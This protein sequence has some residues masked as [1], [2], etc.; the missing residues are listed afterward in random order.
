MSQHGGVNSFQIVLNNLD[1]PAKLVYGF[2]IVI[3]IVYSSAIPSEYR[4]FAD[5]LLG[6]VFGIGII[7]SVT[8]FMGWVYGLLTA[9]AFLL[10]LN[11]ASRSEG[12]NGT[13][14]SQKRVGNQW[15]VEKLLD[16]KTKKIETNK[17]TTQAIHS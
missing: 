7:Y 2:I 8:H 11:G 14:T 10:I 9:M 3:I 15:F 16:E 5:S 17:V 12:F 1:S 6:R 13:I 4:Q